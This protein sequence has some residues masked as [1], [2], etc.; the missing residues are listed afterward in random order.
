MNILIGYS[1]SKLQNSVVSSIEKEEILSRI[2]DKLTSHGLHVT[3]LKH[4]GTSIAEHLWVRDNFF[5]LD[6]FCFVCNMTNCDTLKHDRKLEVDNILH[7]LEAKF[8]DIIHIPFPIEGG[9]V[10]VTKTDVFVGI[11][12]R[13]SI[14][15]FDFLRKRFSNYRFHKLEHQDLHLDCCFSVIDN[16]IIFN[17]S[18]ILVDDI[19]NI[20]SIPN[21]L[22]EFIDIDKVDS[23]TLNTNFI[24]HDNVIFHGEISNEMLILLQSRGYEVEQ[25]NDL[26]KLYTEGGG[27]RCLTQ[28]F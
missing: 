26:N 3:K 4:E 27:I 14:E 12:K 17:R 8:D 2:E 5:T 18:K 1:N 16:T 23:S 28:F 10:V 7:F 13:T 25:I 6:G 24:V 9:D 21:N 11:G 19:A 15:A 20:E 22:Y